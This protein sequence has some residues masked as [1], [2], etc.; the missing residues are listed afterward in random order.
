M[1]I[2]ATR[3][4]ISSKCKGTFSKDFSRKLFITQKKVSPC[5]RHQELK[6]TVIANVNVCI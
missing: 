1:T 4:T 6:K 2:I 3:L 5:E